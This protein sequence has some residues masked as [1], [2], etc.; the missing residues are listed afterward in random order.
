[1][2]PT[3]G[4]K[5]RRSVHSL[6][7]LSLVFLVVAVQ[8]A[9]Q[10]SPEPPRIPGYRPAP[11]RE[12][13]ILQPPTLTN[14]RLHTI[15]EIPASADSYLAS[16]RPAQNFGSDNLFLGYNLV[17]EN[18]YGAERMVLLFDLSSLPAGAII[19]QATLR[20]Y[21]SFSSPADD[22]PMNTVLRRL[23]NPWNEYTV[24]WNN[25]PIG[26]PVGQATGVGNQPGWYEWQVTAVVDDWVNNIHPNY[27]LGII[28]DET[29]QQRERAFYSRETTTANFP[30]LVVDYSPSGDTEPPVVTV[31][32]L[33]I[34]SLRNF[35]VS[36]SGED[37]GG[38][39]IAYYDVQV[40]VD[41]GEWQAWLTNVIVTEAEYGNG[42]NGR[43]Y[44]FRARGVDNAGNEE[45]FGAAEAQTTADTNPPI[46]TI[47][48]LPGIINQNSFTVFWSGID[49]VS[50]IQ[51]YDVQYRYNNGSWNLWL[52][53]TLATQAT[54]TN[55]A[56]GIYAFEVRAVDNL[57]QVEAFLN[58]AEAAVIVDAVPPFVE[59]RLWLPVM[60]KL[61]P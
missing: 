52:P 12:P 58:Q 25:Q 38:S 54:F 13:V 47:N 31:N 18:P 10:E 55:A 2:L 9:A 41:G 27:G 44:Q 5:R 45:P 57:N 51:Y 21:L 43:L 3:P 28:G 32:P 17:G 50:G 19:H 20:L 35:T 39:G 4:R 59:P 56:D 7:L 33:P 8:A 53:Q 30:R 14:E 60:F 16:G 61:I 46:A 34:F 1:M 40:R 49:T 36:W 23:Q 29:I 6:F 24:T 22:A 37:S 42:E 26:K 11:A 48:P 15:I